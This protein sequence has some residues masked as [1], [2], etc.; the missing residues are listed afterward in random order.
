MVLNRDKL[1]EARGEWYGA[2]KE[3]AD[4]LAPVT[5]KLRQFQV[6]TVAVVARNVHL[7]LIVATLI[8]LGWPHVNLIK[9]FFVGFPVIGVL[10][11][12]GV[13][14]EVDFVEEYISEKELLAGADE[15]IRSI[16]SHRPKQEEA[17]VIRDACEK[18]RKASFAS[19]YYTKED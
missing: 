2:F 15:V 13:Y 7:A 16:E 1:M 17:Q 3:L 9:G 5:E 10:P 4:R 11:K 6:G 8:L 18:D 12:T 19:D 14:K